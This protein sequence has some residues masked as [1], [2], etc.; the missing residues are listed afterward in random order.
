MV[1]WEAV[2]YAGVDDPQGGPWQTAQLGRATRLEQLT[3]IAV[4]AIIVAVSGTTM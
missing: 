3:Q 1:V 2:P 4:K